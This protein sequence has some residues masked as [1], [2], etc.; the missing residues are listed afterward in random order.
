MLG[1]MRMNMHAPAGTCLS[2]VCVRVSGS[3][4]M[5]TK[6]E[7]ARGYHVVPAGRIL[8]GR[9]G[10]QGLRRHLQACMRMDKRAC[11]CACVQLVR[12]RG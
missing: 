8:Q 5:R 6:H 10:G 12:V 11:V 1:C 3:F 9:M 4:T 2:L 7:A